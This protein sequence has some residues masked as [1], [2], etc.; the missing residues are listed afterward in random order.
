MDHAPCTGRMWDGHG[1]QTLRAGAEYHAAFRLRRCRSGAD[2]RHWWGGGG[3][4]D[5]CG[6]ISVY[7]FPSLKRV[8]ASLV[9][10]ANITEDR[11]R[12]MK[13]QV[14]TA[15]HREIATLRC[16]VYTVRLLLSDVLYREPIRLSLSGG[17]PRREPCCRHFRADRMRADHAARKRGESAQTRTARAARDQPP[18]Y[19]I[20]EGVADGLRR[21]AARRRAP[22]RWGGVTG[23]SACTYSCYYRAIRCLERTM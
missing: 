7:D 21:R 18:G 6:Q 9:T 8:A 10:D 4:D 12:K 16:T 5:E 17:R 19:Y 22:P 3:C 15:V 2:H 14:R 23:R 1:R 11:G 20:E 13:V